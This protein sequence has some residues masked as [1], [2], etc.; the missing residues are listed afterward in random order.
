MGDGSALCVRAQVAAMAKGLQTVVPESV[1]TSVTCT[2][3]SV[4]YIGY[5]IY[6]EPI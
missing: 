5:A 2:V 1:G 6:R 4:Q 3:E